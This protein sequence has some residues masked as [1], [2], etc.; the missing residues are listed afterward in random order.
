MTLHKLRID[1]HACVYPGPSSVP[2]VS[3]QHGGVF[4]GMR[5]ENK[6]RAYALHVA[7]QF[8]R[9]GMPNKLVFVVRGPTSTTVA[10]FEVVDACAGY[11]VL[12]RV[13][14]AK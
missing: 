10:P 1:A 8:A 13:Q 4:R 2:G 9:Y 5:D 11:S 14:V 6:A 3:V 12:Y 7:Q